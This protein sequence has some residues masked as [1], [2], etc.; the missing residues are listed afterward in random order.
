MNRALGASCHG[1]FSIAKL[2]H[3]NKF[4]ERAWMFLSRQ[5]NHIVCVRRAQAAGGAMELRKMM[6]ECQRVIGRQE[7]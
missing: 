1:A 6:R 2:L 5:R 3:H 4:G 7:E